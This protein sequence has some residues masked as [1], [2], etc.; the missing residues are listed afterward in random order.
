[1]QRFMHYVSKTR[2][3]EEEEEKKLEELINTEVQN[4]W[5][6]KDT[7]IKLE[8]KARK[9]LMENVLKTREEQIKERGNSFVSFY[10]CEECLG[11]R[12]PRPANA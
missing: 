5:R 3:I 8:K 9:A 6:E 7:R 2:K 11:R 1:M 12:M 4:K 10:E